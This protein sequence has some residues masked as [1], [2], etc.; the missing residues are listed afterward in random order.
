MGEQPVDAG[1]HLRQRAGDDGDRH[2]A[3]DRERHRARRVG[4]VGQ[5]PQGDH[6]EHRLGGDGES[7]TDPLD[8]PSLHRARGAIPLMV[9]GVHAEAERGDPERDD[10]PT[11]DVVEI[12][13]QRAAGEQGHDVTG[14]DTA[15]AGRAEQPAVGQRRRACAG[16]TAGSRHGEQPHRDSAA[17]SLP[18][19]RSSRASS[20]CARH[21]PPPATAP[22]STIGPNRSWRRRRP[23]SDTGDR[24]QRHQHGADDLGRR[25]PVVSAGDDEAGDRQPDGDRRG[26]E[27]PGRLQLRRHVCR[28]SNG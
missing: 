3:G 8:P 9:G 1:D 4:P 16:R 2:Q 18:S 10:R 25:R 6:D 14:D 28:P 5:Q 21:R 13:A 17:R 19:L 22:A 7:P 15:P 26:E 11:G 23:S 24:P 20:A 12:D 27:A